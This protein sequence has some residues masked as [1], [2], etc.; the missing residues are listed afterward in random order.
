MVTTKN[1]PHWLLL[2]LLVGLLALPLSAALIQQTLVLDDGTPISYLRY[3]RA[4]THLSGSTY[5][6]SNSYMDFSPTNPNAFLYLC[7]PGLN[8]SQRV[9]LAY[10]SESRNL[11]D[12]V[13]NYQPSVF[14]VD[15]YT[16]GNGTYYCSK[17]D[18]DISSVN[19]LYPGEIL[20]RIYTS[21][22]SEVYMLDKLT[23]NLSGRYTVGVSVIGPPKTFYITP[24]I[25]YDDLGAQ[26]YR[27]EP[28][29]LLSLVNS[30]HDSL[31][32]GKV[33]LGNSVE[34]LGQFRGG[35]QVYVNGLLSL[36]IRMYNPCDPLN[37]SG[38]YI[39]NYSLFN[40]SDTCINISHSS[41]I[42]LNFGDELLDGDNLDNGSMRDN[43]CAINIENSYNITLED[44]MAQQFHKGICITNSTVYIFGLG[45]T[46][47]DIGAFVIENSTVIVVDLKL[48]NNESEIAAY[49]NSLLRVYSANLS[50]ARIKTDFRDSI[51]RSVFDPPPPPN[52]TDIGQWVQYEK[53]SPDAFAQINFFYPDPIPNGVVADNISI[54]RHN[55]VRVFINESY[56]DE[57]LN[58][59]INSTGWTWVN[60]SWLPIYTLISPSQRL[61]ISPN[62]SN[63]SVFAPFGYERPPEPEPEPLPVPTPTPESGASSG[64]GGGGTTP[65]KPGEEEMQR[66]LANLKLDLS[67]PDN[68]T[69]MQGEPG[70]VYFNLTNKGN[71]TVYDITVNPKVFQ[72]WEKTNTSIPYISPGVTLND[73]FNMAPYEKALAATYYVPVTVSVIGPGNQTVTVIER[74]LKVFVIPRGDLARMRVLEYSPTI[75]M[76]PDS[77]MNV[78]FIVENVGDMDLN[79]I[80][81]R[82]NPTDCLRGVIGVNSI[83]KGEVKVISYQVLSKNNG[84]CD[85]NFEFYSNN[86]M[87]G[88][89][90]LT[91]DINPRHITTGA[92]IKRYILILL[93]TGWT[94]LTAYVLNRRRR[95]KEKNEEKGNRKEAKTRSA[96]YT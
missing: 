50:T 47:N 18:V 77:S 13:L 22:L 93:L 87:V 53:T 19:A 58:Q 12:S 57:S 78:S 6:G 10:F 37:E 20:A 59:T 29:L 83:K 55:G 5:Y 85:V 62:M 56:F 64:T 79:N 7:H 35:E 23:Q 33:G 40:L 89:V 95:R 44:M 17:I 86:K 91:F 27:Y 60:G 16:D 88:F 80:T 41:E 26:I 8:V 67:L 36:E 4:N 71:S 75:E 54:Y 76:P 63:Y 25:A 96:F 38:Y 3:D 52:L 39:M 84:I 92:L 68:V 43:V 15:E 30:T 42:V 32:E 14:A 70:K 21:N 72:G 69:L 9:D 61:I 1:N 45:L 74:L 66:F 34:Y 2:A 73:Y 81:V 46:Y 48:S 90:P 49:N 28:H 65:T 94:I 31:V 82:F 51:V 24:K 11:T